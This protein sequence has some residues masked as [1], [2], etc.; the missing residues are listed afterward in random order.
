MLLQV[1]R[2]KVKRHFILYPSLT[3]VTTVTKQAAKLLSERHLYQ[4]IQASL[5]LKHLPIFYTLTDGSTYQK[6]PKYIQIQLV[7]TLVS[8]SGSLLKSVNLS[9]PCAE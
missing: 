1:Q 7:L 3:D 4:Q 6:S 8:I 9:I 2:E 5:D